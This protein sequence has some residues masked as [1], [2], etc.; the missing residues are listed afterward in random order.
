MRLEETKYFYISP[1]IVRII[2]L[3]RIRCAGHVEIMGE[4]K[5]FLRF[6]RKN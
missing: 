2:K 3:R 5:C 6:C 4:G 1:N